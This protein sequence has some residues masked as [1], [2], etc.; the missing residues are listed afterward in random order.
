MAKSPSLEDTLSLLNE[1]QDNP[2]SE[3]AIA[4]LRQVL[5]S[6]H[7]V[8]VARA[9]K[10]VRRAEIRQLIPDLVSSFERFTENASSKDPS[11]LAKK[12]IA[13][14]LYRLE[15]NEENLFLKGIRH[16]QME[17]V[18]G[19]KV[20]TAPGL[21][22]ICALGLVRMNYPDV[23]VELADLLADPESE[24]RIVAARAVR[25][26]DNFQ[27]VPLLRLKIQM[28][29]ADP[30]VMSECFIGLLKL[31]STNSI[32]LIA[33]FLDSYEDQICEMAA[34]AL[35]ESRLNDAF[36]FL[37]NWWQRIRKPELQQICLL[38]I[39]MLRTEEALAFLLTIVLEGRISDA[40]NAID[41]LKIY[42]QDK[43]L[44][45]RIL[46]VVEDRG[47]ASLLSSS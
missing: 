28:G 23:M 8:A 21:R 7:S 30:Q 12:A 25:Y 45:E 17:S 42:Q 47:E 41:A 26:T 2:A 18:W 14:T 34:L 39:S 19:G 33:R 27:G 36:P 6:K 22:G 32:T 9:A 11:C 10:L 1:V 35:G 15:Y 16:V 24:A 43:L 44:W 3:E 29:D 4:T 5:N 38:A 46:R 20:D 31:A 40:K 13:D 37:R